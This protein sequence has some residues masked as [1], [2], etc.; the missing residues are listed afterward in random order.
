MFSH[1]NV[2]VLHRNMGYGLFTEIL[3]PVINELQ[4]C[5]Q[6]FKQS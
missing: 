6:I 1:F 5:Y 2:E 3:Q 4:L